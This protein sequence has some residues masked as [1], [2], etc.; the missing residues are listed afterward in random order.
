MA[1]W[2]MRN[3]LAPRWTHSLL[4]PRAASGLAWMLLR[5]RAPITWPLLLAAAGSHV[6]LGLLVGVHSV[7]VLWP[8]HSLISPVGLL[9]S[10]GRIDASNLYF[11]RNLL[12][13]FGLSRCW[14]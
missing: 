8:G 6:L 2:L 12:V 7:P 4:F 13:E 9:P 5:G 1:W 3:N 14:D 10:A 11:W